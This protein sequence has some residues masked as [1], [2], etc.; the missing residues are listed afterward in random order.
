MN[1]YLGIAQMTG[2]FT[3]EF[4]IYP[5]DFEDDNCL[6]SNLLQSESMLSEFE[7]AIEAPQV[8]AAY[9]VSQLSY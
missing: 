3:H 5:E 1:N 2:L 6:D 8:L 7:A 4:I 9:K